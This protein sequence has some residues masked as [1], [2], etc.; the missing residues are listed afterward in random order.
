MRPVRIWFGTLAWGIALMSAVAGGP[1]PVYAEE[2][3]PVP[4]APGPVVIRDAVNS[5][6]FDLARALRSLDQSYAYRGIQGCGAWT[7]GS[8][9]IDWHAQGVCPPPSGSRV[10]PPPPL[11]L[12]GCRSV[13]RSIASPTCAY[14]ELT[15]GGDTATVSEI[16]PRRIC[17]TCGHVYP[18]DE[19]PGCHCNTGI[20]PAASQSLSPEPTPV[21]PEPPVLTRPVQ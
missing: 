2:P 10:L 9:H 19:Q 6:L 17:T 1:P 5:E 4:T 20:S 8:A 11:V 16:L 15:T 13:C 7:A 21:D 12:G 3:Q 18:R 14:G